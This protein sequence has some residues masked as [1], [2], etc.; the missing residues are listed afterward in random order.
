MSTLSSANVTDVNLVLKEHT[1]MHLCLNMLIFTHNLG[2]WIMV[3]WVCVC[4]ISAV[5]VN[6]S[7]LLLGIESK[8]SASDCNVAVDIRSTAGLP[9]SP[10]HSTL[11]VYFYSGHDKF[12]NISLF[13][14]YLSDNITVSNACKIFVIALCN[15]WQIGIVI[16]CTFSLY[17]F[18]K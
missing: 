2:N 12:I 15:I 1:H 11:A 3:H 4:V 9:L 10:F 16:F 17:I 8:L 18:T 14:C 7:G 13:S 5:S 6:W